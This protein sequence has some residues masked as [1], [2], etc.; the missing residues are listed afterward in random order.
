MAG[1]TKLEC[2]RCILAAAALMVGGC[3]GPAGSKYAHQLVPAGG[4]ISVGGQPLAD[5]TVSFVPVEGGAGT[6]G[7]TAFTAA[8]GRFKAITPLPNTDVSRCVGLIPGRYRVVLRKLAMP[9]GTPVPTD[10]DESEA[11]AR[12]ARNALPSRYGTAEHTPLTVDVP[13]GGSED[14]DLE[15]TR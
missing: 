3:F 13:A 1:R 2:R 7:A 11:L 10:I 4:R 5:A 8:D 15:V 6:V 12:G 9:N 14:L